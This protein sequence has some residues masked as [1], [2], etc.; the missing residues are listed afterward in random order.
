MSS[1]ILFLLFFPPPGAKGLNTNEKE[2][3]LT[4]KT[5]CERHEK[6]PDPS[7]LYFF[8]FLVSFFSVLKPDYNPF[9]SYSSFAWD[10]DVNDYF[11]FLCRE[12]NICMRHFVSAS[13]AAN[14]SEV[15]KRIQFLKLMQDHHHN[16]KWLNFDNTCFFYPFLSY[17]ILQTKKHTMSVVITKQALEVHSSINNGMFTTQKS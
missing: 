6:H 9:S 2:K 5:I 11:W 8:L 17:D 14:T 12:S 13:T 10:A 4:W 7:S 16:Y 3:G 1:R 15:M